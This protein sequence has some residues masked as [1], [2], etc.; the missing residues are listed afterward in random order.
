MRL[1]NGPLDGAIP[2]SIVLCVLL[3]IGLGIRKVHE[4]EGSPFETYELHLGDFTEE[5]ILPPKVSRSMVKRL[6]D[7][8]DIPYR[9]FY[10]DP[11]TEQPRF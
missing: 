11:V 6:A 9:N 10:H 5:L 8:F 4:T 3:E 2:R 1:P 7:R